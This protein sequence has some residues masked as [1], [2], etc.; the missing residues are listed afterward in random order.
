MLRAVF[1]ALGRCAG[2]DEANVAAPREE[3]G[4]SWGFHTRAAD[5]IHQPHKQECVEFTNGF[6]SN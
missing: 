2:A 6:G 5:D 1:E 3:N 4:G